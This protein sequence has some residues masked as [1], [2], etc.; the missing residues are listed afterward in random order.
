[1]AINLTLCF[2]WPKN[3]WPEAFIFIS[4][5]LCIGSASFHLGWR[6]RGFLGW[7]LWK[8][9]WCNVCLDIFTPVELSFAKSVFAGILGL[10]WTYHW[11]FLVSQVDNVACWHHSWSIF[12]VLNF[13]YFL[14][15]KTLHSWI[16]HFKLLDIFSPSFWVSII[17]TH[18]FL[19]VFYELLI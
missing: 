12:T 16:W 14:Y 8:L 1:M 18:I 19:P 5:S 17:L 15:E 9:P 7:H 11:I 6:R 10:I 3:R 13:L 4:L 2:I